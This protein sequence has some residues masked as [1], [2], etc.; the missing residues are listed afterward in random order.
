MRDR[1]A[2]I[3]F[4]VLTA[5]LV[6]TLVVP[7]VMVVTGGFVVQGTWTSRYLLGVF[8]NSLYAEGIYNSFRI[9]VCTTSIAALIALPLAW[10][11]HRFDFRGKGMLNAMV[12]VPLILPP[13]VGA[14]GLLQILGPYGALNALL[15]LG[16]ID[17]LGIS[18]FA[19]VV[20]LQALMF[21]PII[22]LN[23][24]AALAN[25]DPAMEEAAANLGAGG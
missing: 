13:F 15:G 5:I 7:I 21:Y 3:L 19:G 17:W 12:L 6:V 20:A 2:W 22:Y 1:S 10:L 25:V 18:R 4:S 8:Q 14:I 23:V 11:S 16:P 24:S 9:A